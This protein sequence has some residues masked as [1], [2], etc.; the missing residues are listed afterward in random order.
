MDKKNNSTE[1]DACKKCGPS[2]VA[3]ESCKPSRNRECGCEPGK[4]HDPSFLY[5]MD[6]SKCAVGEGVLSPCTQTSNTKCQPCPQGT[7][8]DKV[9]LNEPCTPCSKCDGTGIEEECNAS[10]NTICSRANITQSKIQTSKTVPTVPLTA[11]GPTNGGSSLGPLETEKNNKM[12]YII[13]ISVAILVVSGIGVAIFCLLRRR[14]DERIIVNDPAGREEPKY[15]IVPQTTSETPAHARSSHGLRGRRT[16]NAK[17]SGQ[18]RDSDSQGS[19]GSLQGVSIGN[20]KN[21]TL[22]RDLPSNVFIEL[23]RL[24]NPK[25]SKNWVTLA[26][27]LAFTANE[28]K[29]MELCPEEATQRTLEEWGQRD[30]STVDV[31]LSVFK[32]MKRD[33]CV[34][35]LKQWDS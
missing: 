1:C 7:F 27:H 6:C 32:K 34:Q 12:S 25:S 26:G 16:N 30:G 9:S 35:V 28:V 14:C 18:Q 11:S 15:D 13:G 23:G 4:Y 24:L 10:H 20:G 5:C 22:V 3:L 17:S 31:L 2:Q 33:D 19:S 29:N 21:K 8:S